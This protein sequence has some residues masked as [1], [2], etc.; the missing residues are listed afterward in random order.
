M[1]SEHLILS[2]SRPRFGKGLIL[3]LVNADRY[4]KCILREDLAGDVLISF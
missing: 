1:F 4:D 2:F 3:L